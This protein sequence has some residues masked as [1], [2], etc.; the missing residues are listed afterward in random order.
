MDKNRGGKIDL[1]IKKL[2]IFPE[3]AF[4]SMI[5]K[6]STIY[7]YFGHFVSPSLQSTLNIWPN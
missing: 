1:K 4:W 3:E 7:N 2:G 6:L 5:Y